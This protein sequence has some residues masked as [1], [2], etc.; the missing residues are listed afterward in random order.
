MY[1]KT[2]QIVRYPVEGVTRNNEGGGGKRLDIPS[3]G[4]LVREKGG[5]AGDSWETS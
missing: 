4:K 5:P 3:G 1:F 2:Y